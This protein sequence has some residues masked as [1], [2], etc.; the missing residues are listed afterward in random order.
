MN[1]NYNKNWKYTVQKEKV[2]T[3][4]L[5]LNCHFVNSIFDLL[6]LT[7]F[8][9]SLCY[10]TCAPRKKMNLC[11]HP[12]EPLTHFFIDSFPPFWFLVPFHIHSFYTAHDFF[13]NNKIFQIYRFDC[14]D[15]FKKIDF[16]PKK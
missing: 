10:R 12:T 4:T 16:F 3:F 15:L 5:A 9:K 14:R 6:A 2:L 7:R 13:E 1:R 11:Q 8:P